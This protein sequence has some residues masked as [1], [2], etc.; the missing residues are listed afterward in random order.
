MAFFEKYK[1]QV[2]AELV[3]RNAT[4]AL[5]RARI[6]FINKHP[7][8]FALRRGRELANPS[9]LRRAIDSQSG[10]IMPAPLSLDQK[11]LAADAKKVDNI[12]N[13]YLAAVSYADGIKP[14]NPTG[15]D[16][17]V[18]E[19]ID[20]LAG[21]VNLLTAIQIRRKIKTDKPYLIKLKYP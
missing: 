21:R 14:K 7:G 5:N 6:D 10:R 11:A 15:I 17:K 20:R 8:P 13:S 3:S 4:I 19:R 18:A 16:T 1:A 12:H 2:A 9:L